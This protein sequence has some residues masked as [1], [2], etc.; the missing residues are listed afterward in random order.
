MLNRLARLDIEAWTRYAMLE[1]NGSDYVKP[2]QVE[3]GRKDVISRMYDRPGRKRVERFIIGRDDLFITVEDTKE[4][5]RVFSID[6]NYVFQPRC[7]WSDWKNS[8]A[9]KDFEEKNKRALAI[10][11]LSGEKPIN[12]CDENYNDSQNV[13]I[14][15]TKDD[16][17]YD[18]PTHYEYVSIDQRMYYFDIVNDKVVPVEI[19]Y[20]QSLYFNNTNTYASYINIPKERMYAI[21]NDHTYHEQGQEDWCV[22]FLDGKRV[23]SDME[24]VITIEELAKRLEPT[25]RD[26]IAKQA[27]TPD[28]FVDFNDHTVEFYI[29]NK[30]LVVKD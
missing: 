21:L 30:E 27:I 15:V 6:E 20:N 5:E 28:Q 24:N 2:S 18:L 8:D 26:N 12:L 13:R 14:T 4:S 7:K 1:P 23:A 10:E 22:L 11:K 29:D 9:L 19:D 3:V 17:T 25:I 16:I